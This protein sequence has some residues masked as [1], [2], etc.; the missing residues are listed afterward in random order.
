MPKI[1]IVLPSY[2]HALFLKDRLDSIVNQS[3]TDWELIIIDDCSTDVSVAILTEFVAQYPSKIKHF[4]KNETNSGSGYKSW[5]KGIALAETEYIWI[6]ETDDYSSPT[7]L[8]EMLAVLEKKTNI[9]L[10]FCN[11]NYVDSNKQFLYDSSK[12]TAVLQV[13]KGRSN[14]FEAEVLLNSMPLNPLITN[15][16]SVVFRKP[17]IEIPTAIFQQKQLSDLFLWSYLVNNSNFG[18]LNSNLNFF[19]RHEGST[20]TKNYLANQERLYE[21]MVLYSNYFKL[22]KVESKAIVTHYIKNVL[23]SKKPY[24]FFRLKPFEKLKNNNQLEIIILYIE[25]LISVFIKKMKC[26]IFP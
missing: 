21:E 17:P 5:Q 12:R 13:E 14:L 10:A 16:S 3:Y 18:F 24:R 19:R 23:L 20:T 7:F 25:V 8:E 9:A 22:S 6:A 1:A 2:N 11:S 15:G 4:I 26:R